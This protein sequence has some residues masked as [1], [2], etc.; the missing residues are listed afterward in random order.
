MFINMVNAFT[1][2][3]IGDNYSQDFF[4]TL[5]ELHAM[6]YWIRIYDAAGLTVYPNPEHTLHMFYLFRFAHRSAHLGDNDTSPMLQNVVID[7]LADPPATPEYA[8]L[9]VIDAFNVAMSS[10][11][12]AIVCAFIASQTGK[13]LGCLTDSERIWCAAKQGKRDLGIISLT[14]VLDLRDVSSEKMV[15][16]AFLLLQGL[17][18]SGHSTHFGRTVTDQLLKCENVTDVINLCTGVDL[19]DCNEIWTGA[20]QQGSISESDLVTGRM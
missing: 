18:E 13:M 11:D 2:D 8:R 17:V 10:K 5:F 16:L 6:V 14:R 4:S 7:L 1:A 19:G 15:Q 3:L 12:E 20:I 9:F